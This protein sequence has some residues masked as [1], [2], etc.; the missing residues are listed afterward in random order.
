MNTKNDIDVSNGDIGYVTDIEYE[1]QDYAKNIIKSKKLIVT[2]FGDL[3]IEYTSDQLDNLTL[4]YA[5]TCHKSQGSESKIVL[6]YINKKHGNILCSRNLLYT[7]ITRA[8][9]GVEIFT[10]DSDSIRY[11]IEN[12]SSEKRITSL[13]YHLRYYGGQFVNI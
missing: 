9:F 5:F 1:Y 13:E 12:D 4:A 11:A 8:S 2:F 7:A 3:E 10:V 6:T